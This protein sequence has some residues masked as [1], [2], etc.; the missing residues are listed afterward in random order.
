MPISSPLFNLQ[1]ASEEEV[2]EWI[3]VLVGALRNKS[4]DWSLHIVHDDGEEIAF[5]C[6]PPL[7]NEEVSAVFVRYR[8]RA[9]GAHPTMEVEER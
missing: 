3:L 2:D 7:S 8:L 4:E 9:I 1:P 5:E 6:H